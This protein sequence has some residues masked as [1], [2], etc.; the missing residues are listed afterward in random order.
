MS[1]KLFKLALPHPSTIRQW[2]SGING[3]PGFTSEAFSALSLRASEDK[4]VICSLMV[5]EMAIKKHI[6]WDGKRFVGYVDIGTG[7]DNDTA[8]VAT[9]A[10]V[11][12]VVSLKGHWKVP[13][14]YFFIEGLFGDERANLIKQCLLKLHDVGV[15]IPTVTCDGPSCNFAMLEAL[16]ADLQPPN[17]RPYFDH[18]ADSSLK[19]YVVLEACHMLKLVRNAWGSYGI[20]L[21]AEMMMKK[22]KSTGI[23]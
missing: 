5:D 10:L 6:E 19:V 15:R 22:I 20:I 7:V 12:L 11:F 16:G 2:Y 13:V 1:E 4:E 23:I 3:E 18:P 21:D 17:V 8:P 14:G 9:E